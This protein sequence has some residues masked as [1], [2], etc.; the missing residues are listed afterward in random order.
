MN[1]VLPS[2]DIVT[3]LYQDNDQAIFNAREPAKNAGVCKPEGRA[4]FW[5]DFSLPA[6]RQPV[7][8]QTGLQLSFGLS[9]RKLKY[10]IANSLIQIF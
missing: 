10:I 3:L 5:L 7:R 9:K 8:W 6:P 1:W 2:Q 4:Y